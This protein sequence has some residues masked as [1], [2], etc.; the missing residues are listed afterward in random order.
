[1]Y[2][3]SLKRKFVLFSVILLVISAL[4]MSMVL[5]AETSEEST[6]FLVYERGKAIETLENSEGFSILA[7]YDEFVLVES[8]TTRK[9][10]LVRQGHDIE[11]LENRDHVGLQGHSFNV[12]NGIPDVPKELEITEYSGEES[13]Y[14]IL[15][16][17]GPI[18]PEWKERVE[19]MGVNL[20]GFRNRFNFIAE[21]DTQTRSRVEELD[22]V[23]W[24]G[25]Y[26]PAYRFDEELMD[27]QGKV[28]LDIEFFDGSRPRMLAREMSGLGGEVQSIVRN[29][30]SVEIDADKIGDIASIHGVNFITK[31]IEEYRLFNSDATWVCQTNEVGNRKVTDEGVTGAGEIVTVMDSG[32]Y[33]DHE[34][35][36]RS[37][38]VID[39]YVPPGGN[40]Q[41]GSGA[42]HGTHVSG[43]VLGESPTYGEYTNE[44]G[45]ALEADIVFQDVSTDGQGIN[46]PSD[47]YN[48]GYG[49]YY[50]EG[51]RAHTNSWGGGSGDYGSSAQTSD[52]FIWD[53]KDFNILYAMG[54][55]GSGADTLSVQ[56]EAKNIFSVG[57]VENY[58]SQDS[59]AYF[60]SRGYASD[61]RIKP[62]ITHIGSGLMSAQ[63]G[64]PTGYTSMSG[65]S[66]ATPGVAGQVGQVRHYYEGGFH[67]DAN[68][69]NPTNALVRA[70][71]INGAVEISGS[72]AYQ[73]DNRFPNNDQ[74][75]GRSQLDRALEFDGDERKTIFYDSSQE[76]LELSTGETWETNF[77]VTDTSEDVEITLAWADYPAS[78]GADPTIVNDLDLEVTAPDGTKYIGNAFT[79]Y[80]P[81]YSDPDPTSNPWN[82]PRTGEYDG[83]NVEEDILLLPDQNGVQQGTYQV[84]VSAHDVPQSSQ[85][86]AVVVSGGVASEVAGPS[87]DITR[88]AGG[89]TW[90]QGSTEAIEWVTEENGAPIDSIDLEYSTDGGDTW[91]EIMTGLSDTG[92]Y[93]WEVPDEGTN[94][95]Q[96]RATVYDTDANTGTD[97]S[98]AFTILGTPPESPSNLV[99]EHTGSGSQTL[100]SDDVEGGDLGYT[101]GTSES[102]ASEWGIRD[103]GASSG[104]NSWDFGDGQY[105]K[106]SEYGYL[107][108]LITPEIQ[109]PAD[110]DSAELSFDHWRSFGQQTTYLDGGNLKLST[111]GVNGDYSLITP[112]EG[113]DGEINGDYGN[114]LGGQQA[115]GGTV[116][117]ETVTFD[118]TDYAGETIHLRW[119]AGIEAYDEDIEAG[120]R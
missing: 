74:G 7:N 36:S 100:F 105:Y 49:G 40:G 119:D 35:F 111:N 31:G 9:N 59:M 120:W 113:Y 118:L 86:F 93:N 90:E 62:T 27:E 78:S 102:Q 60:S 16:F 33:E 50:D 83:L 103:N 77:E 115:W 39:N 75:Y 28:L 87:I 81:G 64:N 57:A 17:I 63:N 41:V 5:Q 26:Q 94:E 45:N 54:N 44:D 51:S 104:T 76:D 109:I 117:W 18:K 2:K 52:Q 29:T 1:M 69:F 114:P 34:A 3:K 19:D 23:N 43:T 98:G 48:D 6:C 92:S 73:N 71:M 13:G 106:T 82:G 32:L 72:G 66:M 55:D 56:A 37:G 65:T 24:M 58:N 4:S 68:G 79:G 107:S 88:P 20:H 110:A 67:P 30:I 97:T 53:N 22:F 84:T 15:Q 21:M 42:D 61:G 116:D 10:E 47:M 96:I 108:W 112:N 70:T 11:S 101:T 91:T 8:T 14:Y 38:K 95:A 46:P 25:I 89:E 99:V 12:R 85:P 80:N